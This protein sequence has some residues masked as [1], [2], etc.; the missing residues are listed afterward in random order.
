MLDTGNPDLYAVLRADETEMILVVANLSGKA[1]SNYNLTLKDTAIE[2]GAYLLSPLVR[3]GSFTNLQ[4]G[5]DGRFKD[6]KLLA[7][8]PPYGKYILKLVSVK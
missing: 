4:V 6:F 8:I 3:E 7:V 2:S 5:A 1:V